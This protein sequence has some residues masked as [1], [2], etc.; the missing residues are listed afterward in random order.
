MS[1]KGRV[2]W[3]A[4]SLGAVHLPGTL[5]A[6]LADRTGHKIDLPPEFQELAAGKSS[7]MLAKAARRL[8]R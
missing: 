1:I 8:L 3:T 4:A 7:S 2:N 6:D 5:A